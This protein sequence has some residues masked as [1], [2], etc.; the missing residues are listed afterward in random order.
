[1]LL[2]LLKNIPPAL[3]LSLARALRCNFLARSNNNKIYK[4]TNIRL[5]KKKKKIKIKMRSNLHYRWYTMTIESVHPPPH[6]T[7]FFLTRSYV[8]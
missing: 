8:F 3:S 2:L 4:L 6:I 5:A 1:M 7:F